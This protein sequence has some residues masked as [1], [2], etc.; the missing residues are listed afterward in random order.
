VEYMALKRTGSKGVVLTVRLER[1]VSLAAMEGE[2][3]RMT[4]GEVELETLT[5]NARGSIRQVYR[6]WRSHLLLKV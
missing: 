1:V 6:R 5:F 3:G 2:I 4:S